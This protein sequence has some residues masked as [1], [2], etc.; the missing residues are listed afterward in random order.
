[1]S[2]GVLGGKYQLLEK[3]GQGGM[4]SVWKAR[5]LTLNSNVAVKLIDPAAATNPDALARFFREARAAAALRSPH[6][7]QILDHGVDEGTPFIVMEMLEGESLAKRLERRGRLPPQQVAQ[8]VMQV[9]RAMA[10]AHAAGIVHRDL[11]PDNVFLVPNDDDEV[12]K[13]LDFG[14]AKGEVGKGSQVAASTRTGVLL[15]TPYFMSPEQAVGDRNIDFRTDIWSLGVIAYEC[16]L[17]HKPFEATSM[18]GLMM[19]ICADP[20]PVPSARG[21]V[22]PGFDAWFACACARERNERFPSV[23]VAASELDAL[24]VEQPMPPPSAR[25]LGGTVPLSALEPRSALGRLASTTGQMSHVATLAGVPPRSRALPWVVAVVVVVVAGASAAALLL[26]DRRASGPERAVSA[27][28]A[29]V[30]S[31][32][33]AV[34]P[35]HSAPAYSAP[36][37]A[38]PSGL[39]SAAPAAHG[40]AFRPAARRVTTVAAE[41]KAE[42]SSPEPVAEPEPAAPPPAAEPA[43]EAP[44]PPPAPTP[45]RPNLGF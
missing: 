36:I 12:V 13:V 44:P 26:L 30:P 6:V 5:H 8:I 42:P 1:M 3:L 7:V 41:P 28:P 32:P 14:I 20:L 4:G 22:P 27:H 9:G 43:P 2:G 25:A 10:R 19:A 34:A 39:P 33:A 38:A 21:R 15:G 45:A 17:G 18:A 35:A 11:K 40:P 24:C 31:A 23:K 29:T 16:L 37:T